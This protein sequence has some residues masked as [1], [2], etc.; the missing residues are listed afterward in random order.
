MIKD[1]NFLIMLSLI[2]CIFLLGFVDACHCGDGI[3]NVQGEECDYGEDNGIVCI[4]EYNGNCEWCNNQCKIETENGGYCGDGILDSEFEECDG[5][6]NCTDECLWEEEEPICGNNI[7][8]EGEECD[9]GIFNGFL[10]WAGYNNFCEYCTTSCK[11]KTIYGGYC[12]DG[13][14]NYCYEECDDG[15]NE[16]GDGCSSECEIEEQEP[17]CGDGICNGDETCLTCEEDCGECPAEPECGNNILEENEECDDGEDNG[18]VCD[19]SSSSCDYC[20]SECKIITLP[21]SEENNETEEPEIK[22]LSHGNHYVQF[23]EPNWKCSGWS[24]CIN[25]VKTRT[26][27]DSNYCA[28]QYNKPIEKTGCEIIEQSLIQEKEKNWGLVFLIITSLILIIALV[29]LTTKI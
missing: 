10:C 28:Y 3:I 16:D 18:I 23:C 29:W 20:S 24:E 21:Y 9:W 8:E 26:C 14:K 19:N 13:I 6:E 7:L 22:H 27:Y 5:E 15:N 1:K 4:P 11:L 12:G 2:L 25:G 17:Y